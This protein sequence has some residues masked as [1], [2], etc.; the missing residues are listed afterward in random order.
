M[1]VLW[2]TKPHKEGRV[3]CLSSDPWLIKDF[4]FSRF[5]NNKEFTLKMCV[6]EYTIIPGKQLN[7]DIEYI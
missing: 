5:N 2:N 3:G 7:I 1:G 6:V 4:Q